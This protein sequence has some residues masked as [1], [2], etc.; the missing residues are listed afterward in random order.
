MPQP[1]QFSMLTLATLYPLPAL[2]PDAATQLAV[3]L[4]FPHELPTVFV[5]LIQL[6]NILTLGQPLPELFFVQV[7]YFA[8]SLYSILLQVFHTYTS[9]IEHWLELLL[10]ALVKQ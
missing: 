5:L 6:Y 4:I 7:H 10:F 1:V 9:N 2:S 3:A 8:V